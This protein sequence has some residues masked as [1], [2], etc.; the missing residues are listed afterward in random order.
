MISSVPHQ[1]V[2]LGHGALAAGLADI[3]DFDTA[4]ATSV[5]MASGVANGNSTYH[6]AVTQCVDLTGVAWN[7][8]ADQGV[9]RE[10]HRLH[11]AICADMEGVSPEGKGESHV[12]VLNCCGF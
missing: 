1:T 8:R 6:L 11:L 12:R 5:D 10:G 4:F 2:Q 9:G 3:P 7:P